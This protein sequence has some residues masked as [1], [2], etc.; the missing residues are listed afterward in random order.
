M[1][2][3]QRVATIKI[4][5]LID[6]TYVYFVLQTPEIQRIIQEK[7]KSTNDNISMADINN[8]LIPLPSHSEQKAI[9]EKVKMLFAICDNLEK[10]I[11]QNKIHSEQLMQAV[12]REAFEGETNESN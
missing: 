9:A 7:K 10:E 11:N 6:S 5:E 4:S 12:L 8:F 1:F 3:N 2:V